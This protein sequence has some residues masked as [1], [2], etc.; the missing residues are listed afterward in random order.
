MV[1]ADFSRMAIGSTTHKPEEYYSQ[2]KG[3][4]H[5]SDASLIKGDVDLETVLLGLVEQ[6]G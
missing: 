1:N 3:V 5:D 4:F 2:F 6:A